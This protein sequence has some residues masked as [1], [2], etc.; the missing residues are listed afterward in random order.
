MPSPLTARPPSLPRAST[1]PARMDGAAT[2]DPSPEVSTP[3]LF[4]ATV[5]LPPSRKSSNASTVPRPAK[6]RS[7]ASTLQSLQVRQGPSGPALDA[8]PATPAASSDG[9]DIGELPAAARASGV[10]RLLHAARA[11]LPGGQPVPDLEAGAERQ[12]LLT[13]PARG[14]RPVLPTGFDDVVVRQGERLEVR[15]PVLHSLMTCAQARGAEVDEGALSMHPPDDIAGR[16]ERL[17]G[18]FEV[19]EVELRDGSSAKVEAPLLPSVLLRVLKEGESALSSNPAAAEQIRQV[20]RDMKIGGDDGVATPV[21][22]ALRDASAADLQLKLGAAALM[23]EMR[24]KGFDAVSGA[25][26]GASLGGG[27]A[28]GLLSKLAWTQPM[29]RTLFGEDV[30]PATLGSVA[31]I[32]LSTIESVETV[33][34]ETF[35][36]VVGS[37]LSG[38]IGGQA[39]GLGVGDVKDGLEAGVIAG[40][41]I[42]PSN[43]ITHFPTGHSG[44]DQV[45]SLVSKQLAVF[46]CGAIVPIGLAKQR[47]DLDAAFVQSVKNGQ[48]AP[49]P[50]GVDGRAFT[51]ELTREVMA[52]T[53]D[54]ESAQKALVITAL[55]GLIPWLAEFYLK[56]PKVALDLMQ[57]TIFNPIETTALNSI[58]ILAEHVGGLDGWVTTDARKN[59]Q[60]FS[61]VLDRGAGGPPITSGDLAAIYQPNGELLGPAGRLL[62]R[63]LSSVSDGVAWPLRM[64]GWVGPSRAQSTDFQAVQRGAEQV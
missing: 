35:D 39:F 19:T 24:K 43:L 54:S 62:D 63:G 15:H 5:P 7:R 14:P 33:P 59:E 50:A 23:A 21:G 49:A 48:Q 44:L 12:P 58:L 11:L 16:Y 53:P 64:A 22:E 28:I 30:D 61:L 57:R 38:R 46:G 37:K 9:G 27:L 2:R 4:E 55:A 10:R 60:L 45:I 25:F 31:R 41:S 1:S 17:K 40:I 56:A 20:G 52:L 3:T 13:R 36:A 29:T 18:L 26:W 47:G 34:A 8:G 51:Q 32:I 6:T 42:L